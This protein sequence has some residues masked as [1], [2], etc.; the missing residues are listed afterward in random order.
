MISINK[1]RLTA[2]SKVAILLL[3][4]YVLGFTVLKAA[5]Y[6]Q[7]QKKKEYLAKDLETKK[8][9]YSQ[10]KLEVKRVKQETQNVKDSYISKDEI[11]TR[12][13]EI[14]K[15]MSVFDYTLKYLDAKQMCVDRHVIIAQLT[16]SSPK[17][18]VAGEG[19]LSY[20]GE[21]RKSDTNETL[22]F[23]DY[24]SKPKVQKK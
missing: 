14:F 12:V 13:S 11:K 2:F 17:G 9:E 16:A 10:L 8:I 1:N 6:Y 5:T 18:V 22:Y 4:L 23:V 7:T 3:F 20:L 21:I 19:I 24:I 15:R